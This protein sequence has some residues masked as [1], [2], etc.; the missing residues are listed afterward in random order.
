[1]GLYWI[2]IV[3]I[4]WNGFGLTFADKIC[5]H[6]RK[7]RR[8]EQSYEPEETTPFVLQEKAGKSDDCVVS[9]TARGY[10]DFSV[11]NAGYYFTV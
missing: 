4:F 2:F 8:K 9:N 7:G 10:P 5:Y 6:F 1:L 3:P 11:E